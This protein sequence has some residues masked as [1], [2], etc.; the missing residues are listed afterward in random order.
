MPRHAA[1]STSLWPATRAAVISR[2]SS[3]RPNAGRGHHVRALLTVTNR[4]YG[5]FSTSAYS[6]PPGSQARLRATPPKNGALVGLLTWSKLRLPRWKSRP[7]D[8]IV[9]PEVNP[10]DSA[11]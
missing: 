11:R 3:G 1:N 2:A 5:A 9:D 7:R 10:A 6:F 8:T 4:R